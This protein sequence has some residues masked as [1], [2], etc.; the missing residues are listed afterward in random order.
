MQQ[1]DV[2]V[3]AIVLEARLQ[4]LDVPPDQRREHGVRDRGREALMLEDLRQD[5]ARGGDAHAGEL[6]LEDRAHAALVLG[7]GI[8]VDEADGDGLD[9]ALAQDRGHAPRP[10]VVDRLEELAVVADALVDL[11]AV[12]PAD[13]RRRD[14]LV[15]V[16]EVLL[17]TSA[18]LDDVAEARRRDH[19]GAREGARDQGVRRHRRSVREDCHVAQVD[20]GRVAHA[21][22]HGVDRIG[23]RRGHLRHRHGARV[24]V[25]DADVG[26]RPADVDGYPQPCHSS[27]ITSSRAGS[28]PWLKPRCRS[29]VGSTKPSPA[30][31]TI[32][33]PD[34]NS[35]SISPE[36]T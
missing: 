21:V 32:V 26:E 12:A 35:Y 9:A 17:R 16:P 31:A 8:G 23:G 33:P 15:G 7:V 5:V 6:L 34:S 22:D 36:M 27:S 11:E 2:A 28:V 14:V 1:Q 4:P 24:L 10:G 29:S 25:E 3:V 19:R 13:V 20:L 30:L 18:D